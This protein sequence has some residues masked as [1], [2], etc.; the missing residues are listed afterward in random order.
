MVLPQAFCQEK[1]FLFV[2]EDIKSS[3]F[4]YAHT[5]FLNSSGVRYSYFSVLDSSRL[6]SLIVMW[7]LHICLC[8]T[9][10]EGQACYLIIAVPAHS[11]MAADVAQAPPSL[12]FVILKISPSG[13]SDVKFYF[14]SLHP[15]NKTIILLLS[16]FFQNTFEV[17]SPPSRIG[18]R[19]KGQSRTC[20]LRLNYLQRQRKGIG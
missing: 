1:L 3:V 16:A 10:K 14:T 7:Q 11:F 17:S 4:A 19:I 15:R 6:S 13:K 8:L 9:K 20:G 2:A 12:Q 18:A 5:D